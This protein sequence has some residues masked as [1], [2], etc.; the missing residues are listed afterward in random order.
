MMR[1]A[2]TT[3]LVQHGRALC[4]R[5]TSGWGI[6]FITPERTVARLE[7]ESLPNYASCLVHATFPERLA[8][9]AAHGILTEAE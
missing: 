8:S 9:I 5:A 6:P 1:S 2:A 7:H 3:S 4:T